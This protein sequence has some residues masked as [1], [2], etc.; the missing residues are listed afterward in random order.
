MFKQLIAILLKQTFAI[1]CLLVDV[2]VNVNDKLTLFDVETF[3]AG[4][5]LAFTA[6]N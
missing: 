6:A 2:E 3:C 5:D 1:G 4:W